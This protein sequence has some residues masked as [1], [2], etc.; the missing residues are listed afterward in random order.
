M[1]FLI[2]LCMSYIVTTAALQLLSPENVEVF[3]SQRG[4]VQQ[5]ALQSLLIVWALRWQEMW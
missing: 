5:R 4:W 2:V 1:W 3:L